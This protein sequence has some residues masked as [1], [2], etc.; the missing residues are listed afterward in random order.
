MLVHIWIE[1]SLNLFSRG[2]EDVWGTLA[3]KDSSSDRFRIARKKMGM[4][5]VP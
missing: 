4:V 5:G 3:F 2:T 1:I